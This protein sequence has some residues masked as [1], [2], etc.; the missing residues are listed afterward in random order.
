LGP[1]HGAEGGWRPVMA[2]RRAK[3]ATVLLGRR[4]RRRKGR[5]KGAQAR[6]AG[7]PAGTAE[8]DGPEGHWARGKENKIR[9]QFRIDFQV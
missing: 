1:L 2:Q 6:W 7:W 8:W 9:F 4:G 5:R 3:A